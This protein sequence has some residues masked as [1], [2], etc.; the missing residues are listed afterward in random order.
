MPKAW[1]DIEL[2]QTCFA[3]P[4]QYDAFYNGEQVGYLRLRHGYFSVS[5][6]AVK[7]SEPI[8][9]TDKVY[10]DGIFHADER[11]KMLKKARK[12][13]AAYHG[14]DTPAQD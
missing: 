8:W 2:V 7:F 10:G 12:K 13:I 1:K 5:T 14:L 11:D 9:G 3:C 4:E 6:A